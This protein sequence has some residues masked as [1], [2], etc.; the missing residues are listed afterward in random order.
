[1][2]SSQAN[3]TYI[4]GNIFSTPEDVS[5]AHCVSKDL[6]MGKGI[7]AQFKNIFGNIYVLEKQNRK[8]GEVA[9][10]SLE[11]RFIFNLITKDRY[12]NKPTYESLRMSLTNLRLL[13]EH[14]NITKLAMPKI[15][16]GLDRLHWPLVENIIKSIF[17]NSKI[18]ISIYYL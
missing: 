17:A 18:Q 13:C 10:L 8:V 16:C 4:K 9:Y 15:G 7:A 11:D 6:K 1:M 14:Y 2:D 12:F 5:F 3:I